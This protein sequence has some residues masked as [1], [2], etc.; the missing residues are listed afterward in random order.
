MNGFK[1]MML[2]LYYILSKICSLCIYFSYRLLFLFKKSCSWSL[3]LKSKYFVDAVYIYFYAYSNLQA[4]PNNLHNS[5]FHNFS[6]SDKNA[7]S[8]MGK[9]S[10]SY[11]NNFTI[12]STTCQTL[13][14]YCHWGGRK[15]MVECGGIW[16]YLTIELVGSHRK[17]MVTLL[18]NTKKSHKLPPLCGRY[19]ITLKINW[20]C[21]SRISGNKI[22]DVRFW[23]VGNVQKEVCI[24]LV[25][26]MRCMLNGRCTLLFIFCV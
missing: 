1:W 3:I 7:S 19:A 20:Y 2:S 18:N 17:I 23:A 8:L 10:S 6:K 22:I 13:C 21:I 12:F 16:L 5:N 25:F 24:S 15:K 9:H 4:F 26:R 14:F 11:H